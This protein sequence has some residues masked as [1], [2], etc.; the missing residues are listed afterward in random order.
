[1][2]LRSSLHNR[3]D[4]WCSHWYTMGNEELLASLLSSFSRAPLNCWYLYSKL[5]R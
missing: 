4:I 1:M 3:A 5:N 2:A